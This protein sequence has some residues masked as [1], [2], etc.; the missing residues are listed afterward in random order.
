MR[1]PKMESLRFIPLLLIAIASC[2]LVVGSLS[3]RR[4]TVKDR[5]RS[6][7][8]KL[9]HARVERQQRLVNDFVSLPGATSSAFSKEFGKPKSLMPCG[10]GDRECWYYDFEGRTMFVC[11]DEHHKVTCKGSVSYLP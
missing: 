7:Q 4:S 8:L 2:S 11:F 1:P 3:C 10:N 6:Q 9:L 5:A